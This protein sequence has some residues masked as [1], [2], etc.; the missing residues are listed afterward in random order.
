MPPL[1]LPPQLRE[2]LQLSR[3]HS[4]PPP[5]N[6]R[7]RANYTGN[8]ASRKWIFAASLAVNLVCIVFAVAA[9]RQKGGIRWLRER[10]SPPRHATVFLGDSITAFQDWQSSFPGRQVQNF[11]R[12][13]QTTAQILARMPR[14]E[15]Q[16]PRALFLMAGVNDA[17]QG[18]PVFTAA[19][20][21]DH[22][23][24]SIQRDSP[25]TEIYLISAL[26]VTDRASSTWPPLLTR[27]AEVNRWIAAMNR[28]I[29]TLADGRKTIYVDVDGDF[30]LQEQMNPVYTYD[31]VH[32][33]RRGYRALRTDLLPFVYR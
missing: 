10:L 16:Q 1:K 3:Q 23:V 11:G 4:A 15:E 19:S 5:P 33:N 8:M 22:I 21:Y 6:H 32:L 28:H 30:L 20:N 17:L 18:I 29:S 9:V 12:P 14:V 2:Y 25:E 13:G 24:R 26:P 31:G 7:R 27:A